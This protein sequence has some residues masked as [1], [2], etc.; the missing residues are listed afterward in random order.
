MFNFYRHCEPE[1]RSNPEI[2]RLAVGAVLCDCPKNTDGLL[3]VNPRNDEK[4][5][6]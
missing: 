6:I 2:G 1:R 4:E 5:N 3:R